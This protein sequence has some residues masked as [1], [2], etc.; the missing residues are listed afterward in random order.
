[1]K[2]IR[3]ILFVC[4]LGLIGT[5]TALAQEAD[6]TKPVIDL[7]YPQE[8]EVAKIGDGAGVHFVVDLE[9]DVMLGSYKVEIYG[10]TAATQMGGLIFDQTWDISDKQKAKIHHHH[11]V[12]PKDAVPGSYSFT[13]ICKDAAGNEAEVTRNII[14]R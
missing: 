9:D 11:I 14:L 6:T 5:W 8:G 3:L 2:T 7:S 4:C 1:M 13:L 12:I 10:N